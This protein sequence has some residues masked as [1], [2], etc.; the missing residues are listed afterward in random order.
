M[1]T[2]LTTTVDI[3]VHDIDIFTVLK[4]FTKAFSDLFGKFW[5]H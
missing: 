1:V 3:I 5:Y 2:V 4:V